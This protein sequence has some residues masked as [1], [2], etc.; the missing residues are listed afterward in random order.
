MTE[1]KAQNHSIIKEYTQARQSQK[2]PATQS[3]TQTHI[4]K[5]LQSSI[6]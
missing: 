2:S 1:A 3:P 6:L 5:I 4:N